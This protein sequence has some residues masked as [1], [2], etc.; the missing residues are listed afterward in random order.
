MYH[1]SVLNDPITT[2]RKLGD[3]N[4]GRSERSGDMSLRS[5]RS[6]D[7]EVFRTVL[8]ET[9]RVDR[10]VVGVRRIRRVRSGLVDKEWCA[11]RFLIGAEFHLV[12][13]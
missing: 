3:I 1:L 7:T 4:N 6:E 11:F 10:S 5:P 13:V 12:W 9:E 8:G 2:V